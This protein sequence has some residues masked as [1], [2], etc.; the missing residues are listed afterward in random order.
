ML[1]SS[2]SAE[3]RSPVHHSLYSDDLTPVV[4]RSG[5]TMASLISTSQPPTSL[6]SSAS[7]AT[8]NTFARKQRG[9][10]VAPSTAQQGPPPAGAPV[11]PPGGPL[12]V[13]PVSPGHLNINSVGLP[14][15]RLQQQLKTNILAG[16]GAREAGPVLEWPRGSIPR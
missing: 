14:E 2:F 7:S 10:K 16:H 5:V 15:A 4:P 8:T 1:I 12:T 3:M 11:S 6:L 13:A 9:N